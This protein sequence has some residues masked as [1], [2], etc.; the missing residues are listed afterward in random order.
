MIIESDNI[1]FEKIN[2]GFHKATLYELHLCD[3]QV[4]KTSCKL[5]FTNFNVYV[6]LSSN[7]V[8]RELILHIYNQTLKQI[9]LAEYC[10]GNENISILAAK[11]ILK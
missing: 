9:E 5:L 11:Q 1:K 10:N 7:K 4:S 6:P 3:L 8:L 2:H